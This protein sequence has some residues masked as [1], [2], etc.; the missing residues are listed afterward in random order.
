MP[1]Y[2]TNNFK[3]EKNILKKLIL[4]SF[5]FIAFGSFAQQGLQMDFTEQDS[6]QLRLQRQMEYHQLISGSVNFL[7][8]EIK[9]PDINLTQ[10]Y[11]K[12]YTLNIDFL[13]NANYAFNGFST[14]TMNSFHS[15]FYRNGM[16]LSAAAY[17]LGDKFTLGGFSYGTNS[18]F[19]T[20]N[21]NH[22]M[23]NFDCYGSTLFLQYKV[24]KK[25]KIETRINVQ[26]R[27]QHPGF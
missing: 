23:N 7:D 5:I 14:G 24:S 6:V 15:P 8:G 17:Q 22:G 20:P 21:F 25:F 27:G 3:S 19:S 26:Q 12:R 18:I 11:L 13:A 4:I 16:I 9:L 1:N 10:E 2:S